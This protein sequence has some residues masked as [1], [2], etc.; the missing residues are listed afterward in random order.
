MSLVKYAV[1]AALAV[2]LA[3]AAPLPA[4]AGPA[5]VAVLEGYVGTWKGTGPLTGAETGTVTCRMTFKLSSSKLSYT[6]RCSY[7]GGAS[8]QSFNGTLSYNDSKN[9][10]E[11]KS[12]GKTFVGSASGDGVVFSMNQSTSR[13]TFNSTLSLNGNSISFDVSATEKSS[14]DTTTSSVKFA[15][16]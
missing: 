3:V 4:Y 13:G 15:R 10:Y 16:S 8:S 5:E 12:G 2:L 9:R 6:G 14:G 11:A 1:G 7:T